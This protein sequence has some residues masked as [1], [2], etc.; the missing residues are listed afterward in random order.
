MGRRQVWFLLHAP[1]N[2]IVYSEILYPVL[3]CIYM[4]L[5]YNSDLLVIIIAGVLLSFNWPSI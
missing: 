1:S 5:N 3:I 2:E 4:A